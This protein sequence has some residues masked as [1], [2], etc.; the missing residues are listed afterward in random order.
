MPTPD[1]RSL[2]FGIIT[3][4]HYSATD[5]DGA[6]TAAALSISRAVALW[7]EESSYFVVQ[8]GDLISREGPEA[9]TDLIEVR[10]MLA[11]YPGPIMHVP[12]NHCLA[13]PPDRFLR[14]MGIPSPYYSF[15]AGGVRFIVLHSMDVSINSEPDCDLDRRMLTHYRDEM[16]AL[17]YCGAVGTR[18]QE[19]LTEELDASVRNREQVIVLSHL[20]LLEETTDARHGL[21]WNHETITEILFRYSNI[22]AC[23]SGHYHP[24]AYARRNGIHFI[25]IPGFI[26]RN[27]PPRFA[28]G[29]VEIASGRLRISA[30]DGT[31]LHDLDFG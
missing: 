1:A 9:E 23:L 5:T 28:C 4:I 30:I 29:T 8:L 17:F 31:L 14:I 19:W 27:E 2:R 24:G 13:V 10:D 15:A 12:G 11:R 6:A 25:V 7:Q 18:Q 26:N 22:Q 16:Q 20:P 3:D 21:C